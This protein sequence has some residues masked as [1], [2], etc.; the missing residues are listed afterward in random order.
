[1]TIDLN[2]VTAIDVHVHVQIDDSGRTASPPAL[3]AAMAAYFGSSEPPRTVDATAHYYRERK[4]A[5]VVFTVDATTNLGHAPNSIDD[6]AA[7]AH[8]NA[9]VL[10]PFGSVDPLQ[11]EAAVE[12]ARRQVGELGV[13]GFKFHP[14]VQGFDPSADEFDPLWSTIEELGVPI[15]V[16]TGQTGAGAGTPG[17]WGFRLSLS[18]PMLLDD[19][20]A[21]H[22]DLQVI[23]AH[24]SV[25]WQDEALSIATHKLNTWIDLSGWSPKYFSPALVRAARTYLKHKMLFGSDMPALTPDR[26]LNDVQTLEFPAD[27]HEM[28][29]KQNAARLLGLS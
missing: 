2:A 19:V 9:D 20:A 3:T 28:I 7:G 11:G 21:R 27:V 13:R 16:H 24:P 25:P 15:I 14:S 1:M 6:L 26:W 17:G 22:P 18:N 23:M 29:V 10:I 4:M 5:A 12:E 8:R